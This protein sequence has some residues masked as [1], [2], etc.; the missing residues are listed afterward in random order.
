MKFLKYILLTCVFAVSISCTDEDLFRNEVFFRLENGG[1]VRFAG[2][3]KA[4][5]GAND[6]AVWSYNE[7]VEDVNGNL[8]SY[9]VYAISATDTALVISH[10]NPKGPFELGITSTA[11]AAALNIDPASFQFGQS[12]RFWATATRVDGVVFDATPLNVDFVTGEV[13]GNTQEQ[14]TTTT[15]YRNAL[16]FTLTIAC[17][18]PPDVQTYLGTMNITA[19]NW[20]VNGPVNVVAGPGPGEITLQNVQGR[21]GIAGSSADFTMR[22]N[23]DQ[24]VSFT[25]QT[26][27]IHSQFGAL[28]MLPVAGGNF[29]FECSNNAIIVRMRPNVAAGN[30]AI[31]TMRLS[32]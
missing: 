14:L 18:N 4:L 16:A 11:V 28:R 3:F 21:G 32:K 9:D 5:I 31:N 15:G 30:F 1:F 13:T 7:L 6:P 22:L 25:A 10:P 2:P 17:P 19:S 29:T 8:S 20:F 27:W 26:G 24:T 12:I 23:E